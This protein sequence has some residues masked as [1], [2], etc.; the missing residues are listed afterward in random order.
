M[1]EPQALPQD[2]KNPKKLPLE[3]AVFGAEN[4]IRAQNAGVQRIELNA[5]GSYKAGGLTP[6]IDE[7]RRCKSDV[8]VPIRIM[9]RPRGAPHK[10]GDLDFVYKDVEKQAMKESIQLFKDCGVMNPITGDGFVFGALKMTKDRIH[11][12]PTAGFAVDKEFCQELVQI[13][14]PFPCIFHRAFDQIAYSSS[15][16]TTR[17]LR[18]LAACGFKGVLTSGGLGGSYYQHFE[19][20][21][22]IRCAMDRDNVL[23]ELQLIVGGGL[24]ASNADGAIAHLGTHNKGGELWLHTAAVK[25]GNEKVDYEKPQT[26]SSTGNEAIPA[27]DSEWQRRKEADKQAQK[28]AKEVKLALLAKD[29]YMASEVQLAEYIDNDVNTDELAKL[30]SKLALAKPV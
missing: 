25:G 2:L 14:K 29:H 24:R 7:L 19:K 9:I 10:C 1:A 15:S 12:D 8:K 26:D 20:L 6:E 5:P 13:A 4:A 16:H 23:D 30:L 28:A 21:D 11:D 22:A 18:D 3:C 17:G 27:S